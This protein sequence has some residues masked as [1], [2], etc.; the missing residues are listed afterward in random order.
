[1]SST[2][3]RTLDALVQAGLVPEDPALVAV[4]Q[5]FAVGLTEHVVEQLRAEG[6]TGPLARQYLPTV[7]ELDIQ[8]Q[9]R[10]D[11]IG[12]AAHAPVSGIVHRYPDRVLLKAVHVCPVYCRFCFRR[13]QVGPEGEMLDRPALDAALAY[14]A[15]NPGV[16]EVILSGGDPLVMSAGRLAPLAQAIGEIP[17]VDLLRVHTRVPVVD[18]S[19]ITPELIAALKSGPTPWLVLHVNHASELAGAEQA[20]A[21]LVDAG[22][23]MLSQSVLL[24]GVN[25]TVSALEELFRALLKLRVKPYYLHQGDQAQGTGHFRVPIEEG[26][27][28]MRELRGRISGMALPTYMLDIPGGFGKVPIGPV[29]AK[30]EGEAWQ[31][32]DPSGGGHQ[33][34]G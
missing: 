20:I 24:A 25:D 17:H 5:H 3:L 23:P 29:Y 26:Q 19:R 32:Q 22:I 18:P 31:V 4:A 33:V 11:P 6:G 2:S 9:E 12:D 28:L 21:D 8:P 15:E 34:P 16:H 30:R 27:D 14:I 1:M 10:V 13:E 7:A